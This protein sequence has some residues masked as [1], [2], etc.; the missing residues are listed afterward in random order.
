M[1]VLVLMGLAAA[2]LFSATWIV[3]RFL[4]LE[5]GH[6]L[7]TAVIRYYYVLVLTA[8]VLLVWRGPAHLART[9][10][11]F[12]A[13]P[14]WWL[15]AGTMGAGVF[16][17]GICFSAAHAPGWVTAVAW[18]ATIVATPLVL[19]CFGLKVPLHGV[20][21]GLLIVAGIGLVNFYL[22]RQ[23]LPLE[24]V[25]LGALPVLVSAFAY[26][27]GNQMLNQARH[28]PHATGLVADPFSG[29]FLLALGSLPFWAVLLLVLT[30]PPPTGGQFVGTFVVA[31]LSGFLATGLFLHARNG[32]S[33][34]YRIAAVD[35]TQGGE[36]P[37]TLLAEV[38]LLG[39]PLPGLAGWLGMACV[40][41]GL[42][43]FVLRAEAPSAAPAPA[44]A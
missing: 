9:L 36:V 22:L 7:W 33:D 8:G 35:A 40:L 30:P 11:L 3:N 14:L 41:I 13:R 23:G 5:G 27:V 6:W 1:A 28:A 31:L 2:A 12:L 37:C 16:Y 39:A 4:A 34:P 26:P 42:V 20:L 44:P 29:L 17:A 24:A 21:F 32:S 19:R 10:R 38:I 43:G 18:Q 25:L 15:A